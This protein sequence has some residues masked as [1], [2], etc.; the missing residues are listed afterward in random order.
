VQRQDFP[1]QAR[2]VRR[3]QRL[4][5][6]GLTPEDYDR[7]VDEQ[8]GACAICLKP[9]DLDPTSQMRLGVDHD[10][11]TGRVRGLLCRPCNRA[12]GIMEDD[13]NRAQRMSDYLRLAAPSAENSWVLHPNRVDDEWFHLPVRENLQS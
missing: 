10:H 7:M 4:K 8:D 11:G 13:P 6:Y 5:R 2:A 9:G 3:R 12:V 1:E